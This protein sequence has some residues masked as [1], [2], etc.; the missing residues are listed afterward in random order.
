M[1]HVTL[2][3]IVFHVVL[4]QALTFL[5]IL[6]KKTLKFSIILNKYSSL[7]FVINKIILNCIYKNSNIYFFYFEIN[8]IHFHYI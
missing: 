2:Y 5:I 3:M 6:K 8:D 4:K 1:L 7:I